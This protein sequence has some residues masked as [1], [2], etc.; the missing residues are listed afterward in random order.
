MQNWG[1]FNQL[2]NWMRQWW[3]ASE[4]EWWG[5]VMLILVIKQVLLQLHVCEG[6][7]SS[8]SSW[9]R[10]GW[11]RSTVR[12][13]RTSPVAWTQLAPSQ[14]LIQFRLS[15]LTNVDVKK[16][17]EHVEIG[18]LAL[19]TC[20]SRRLLQFLSSFLVFSTTKTSPVAVF[21]LLY[22]KMT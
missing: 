20:S 15:F 10:S 9:G 12:V 14:W 19:P 5:G 21:N 22:L 8:R 2:S 16:V 3:L 13:T 6:S 1:K 18:Q 17:V 11:V 4:V 7:Q